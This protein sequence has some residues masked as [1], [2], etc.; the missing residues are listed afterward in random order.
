[1]KVVDPIYSIPYL[2][3][4]L[5]YFVLA[6]VEYLNKNDQKR[7]WAV[8]ITCATVF[9]M[10]FGLRGFIGWD[11]TN[12]YPLYNSTPDLFH[13]HPQ[14]FQTE[15]GFVVYMS[16]F[17][18]F[19]LDYH[20]FIFVS[21]IIHVC[22]LSVFLKRY[23]PNG[24]Y[25]LGFI[26]FIVMGGF[27]MEVDA[28]R[29]TMSILLFLISIKHVEQRNFVKFYALNIVGFFFHIS[30]VIYLPLYF[31]LHKTLNRWVVG[32]IFLVGLGVFL[33][34]VEYIKPFL[35]GAGDLLGGR[36]KY[37]IV[38]YLN[39]DTYSKSYGLTIGLLERVASALLVILYYPKLL[40]MSKYGVIFVNAFVC[41]F[42]SFFYFS[43]MAVIS[44]RVGL[45][46]SFSYWILW[47][48]LIQVMTDKTTALSATFPLITRG[49]VVKVTQVVVAVCFV[50][51]ANLKI[52]GMTKTIL[53]Q[54]DSIV[55]LDKSYEER[56]AIFEGSTTEILF[57]E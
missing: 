38:N 27:G 25:V 26:V 42:I 9:V 30:A 55:C 45:L 8:I 5:L 39:D 23:L 32:A 14:A 34:Q 48:L 41:Y 52:V 19:A 12:Y 43:E 51:Y 24:L 31:L 37:G 16:I 57:G 7:Q 49:V 4:L 11:W 50:A 18:I 15:V 47:P 29:N 1:M 53:Y 3:L 56:K 33:L 20:A 35:D 21:S 36:F 22:L 10:F 2:I 13:L 28:M 17:K 54:Y 44:V 6:I 46:F 40:K